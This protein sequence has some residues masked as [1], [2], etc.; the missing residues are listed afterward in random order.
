[1]CNSYDVI[2]IDNY[3]ISNT[4]QIFISKNIF[5]CLSIWTKNMPNQILAK[6][7]KTNTFFITKYLN[8][9]WNIVKS[10]FYRKMTDFR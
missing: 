7:F 5:I 10:T 1:M 6:Y 9:H 4:L 2:E 8:L 3:V